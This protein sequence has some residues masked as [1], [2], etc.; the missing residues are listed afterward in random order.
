M[1]DEVRQ[2]RVEYPG[3]PGFLSPQFWF[4]LEPSGFAFHT[5]FA[6]SKNTV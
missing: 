3:K 6:R 5:V 1:A 2:N 4:E